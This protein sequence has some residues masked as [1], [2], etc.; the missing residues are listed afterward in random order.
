MPPKSKRKSKRKHVPKLDKLQLEAALARLKESGASP[1]A[2]R[3]VE[4]TLKAAA[5]PDSEKVDVIISTLDKSRQKMIAKTAKQV[6]A[7]TDSVMR[8]GRAALEAMSDEE[9]EKLVDEAN[10]DD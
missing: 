4:E 2:I 7:I 6:G 8:R 1:A 9:W 10:S 3:Q 5:N